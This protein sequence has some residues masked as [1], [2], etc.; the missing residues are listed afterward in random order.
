MGEEVSCRFPDATSKCISGV[1]GI[2][3]ALHRE[4]QPLRR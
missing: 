4:L 3:E 1:Y 2:T